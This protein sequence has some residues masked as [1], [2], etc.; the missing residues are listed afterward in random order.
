MTLAVLLALAFALHSVVADHEIVRLSFEMLE[1]AGSTDD[2]EH[3]AFLVRTPAGGLS[4]LHWPRGRFHAA[5]WTGPIP[6]NA[7]GV[8]HTHPRSRPMPSAQDRA[9]AR[10]LRLPFYVV[11]RTALCVVDA[12]GRTSCAA[13]T[14]WLARNGMNSDVALQWEPR[15]A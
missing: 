14:P 11:S 1:K 7:L 9:E 15:A 4:L 6:R 5:K 12:A 2:I 10:R 3:A 13:R 8:I